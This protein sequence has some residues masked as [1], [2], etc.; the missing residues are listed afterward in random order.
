LVPRGSDSAPLHRTPPKNT[1]DAA[2]VAEVAE[3]VAVTKAADDA[4]AADGDGAVVVATVCI[5]ERGASAP[6]HAGI[7]CAN[8]RWP[9]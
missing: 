7:P 6:K 1:I 2:E 3:A 4:E 9:Q 5:V 8:A